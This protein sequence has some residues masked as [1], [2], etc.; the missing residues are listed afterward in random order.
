MEPELAAVHATPAPSQAD[1][2]RAKRQCSVPGC[3]IAEPA[4]RIFNT[5]TFKTLLISGQPSA[6]TTSQS[7]V[8]SLVDVLMNALQAYQ[9]QN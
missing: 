9:A 2:A 3:R 7:E 4:V 5:L 8:Q 1:P 6:D